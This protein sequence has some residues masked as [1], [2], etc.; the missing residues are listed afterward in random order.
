VG[1]IKVKPVRVVID[2]DVVVSALLFGGAPAKWIPLWKN[3]PV[4]P[5]LSKAILDEVMRVLAYPRFNLSEQ[6]IEY[7]LYQEILPFFHSVEVPSGPTIVEKDPSDDHFIR[8]A[9]VARAQYIISGDQHLLSLENYGNI[10]IVSPA[11]Y[12]RSTRPPQV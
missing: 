10:R 12:L 11:E 2:T 8:C 3:G 7:L 1:A 9:K 6:E 5:Y 4:K